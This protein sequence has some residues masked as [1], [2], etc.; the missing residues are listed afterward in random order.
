MYGLA[1]KKRT[2]IQT[3]NRQ[4]IRD[5]ALEIFARDGFRG[6]TVDAIASKAGMSKPNLLYYFPT[7]D[8]IYREL[9]QNLLESWLAP[10]Q[11]VDAD[12]EPTEQIAAYIARKMALARDFPMESRLFANEMIRGAP[13]L[14]DVLSRDLKGLVD[15]K[16]ALIQAWMDDGKLAPI[17]PHHLIFAIWATTQHYADFDVQVSAVLGSDSDDRFSGAATALTKIFLDGLRPR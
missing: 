9:L 4:T 16:A 6:A 10:L 11:Q 15:E 1:D 13:I 17:D 14:L 7:K 5:A 8:E 12:G 3:E 2:R